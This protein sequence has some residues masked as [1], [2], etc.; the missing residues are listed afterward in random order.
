MHRL[1]AGVEVEHAGRRWRVHQPLGPDAILL[2]NDAG[3]IVSA[4]PIRVTFPD[5]GPPKPAPLVVHEHHYSEAQWAEAARR[6][7]LLVTL[8]R[9]PNRTV[10]QVNA[11]AAE[12]GLKERRVWVLLR[13]ITAG[14]AFATVLPSVPPAAGRRMVRPRLAARTD[15]G[16]RR[17]RNSAAQWMLAVWR[18]GFVARTPHRG[19]GAAMCKL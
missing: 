19:P 3:E 10:C 12:L 1:V 5:A 17:P 18:A 8:A 4:D 15:C 7:D 2:Q 13:R 6:R 9:S 16:L 11:V 14:G